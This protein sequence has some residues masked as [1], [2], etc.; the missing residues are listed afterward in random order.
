MKTVN[1]RGLLFL[2]ALSASLL[3]AGCGSS[4]S[5]STPVGVPVGNGTGSGNTMP[6]ALNGGPLATSATSPEIYPDA[7]FASVTICVP[8]TSTCQTIDNVLV[9]TGSEGLRLL[10]SAITLPTCSGSST[11]GCLPTESVSGDQVMNCVSFVDGSFLWGPVET[12]TVQLAGEVS[13]SAVPIQVISSSTTNIPTACSSG[14]VSNDENTVSSL[15]ANGILGIGL[16][17]DDCGEACDPSYVQSAPS[18][19]PYYT[20][21]GSSCTA[22]LVPVAQQVTNP[23]VLFPTDNNGTVFELGT[24][25][26]EVEPTLTGNVIFGINTESNNQID[27]TT[28]NVFTTDDYDNFIVNFTGCTSSAGAAGVCDESFIDSGS[29]GYFFPDSSIPNCS[30]YPAFFCPSGL[31]ALT[32]TN[33]DPNTFFTNAVTFNVDNADNLFA[34]D[35]GTDAVYTTLAGTNSPDSSFDW[36]L[37]FFFGRN[38]FTA[39]DGQAI[40]I[41]GQA[42]SGPFW[43]Y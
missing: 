37:P 33:E 17:P 30:D 34:T 36:G 38:V 21:S 42:T 22:G 31:T 39:I 26:S 6:I 40:T 25:S 16:E 2:A 5:G 7:A 28:A 3:A 15:L 43:A 1:V 23:V 18:G 24:P 14:N 20:C 27:T 10:A 19:D 11:S 12:A 35:N 9:D 13:T 41:N 4:N 29:N 8:N 32:A